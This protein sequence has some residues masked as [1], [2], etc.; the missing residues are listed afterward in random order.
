VGPDVR[1]HLAV[2]IGWFGDHCYGCKFSRVFIARFAKSAN[3]ICLHEL[4]RF[5]AIIGLLLSVCVKVTVSTTK[6]Q[7]IGM[8]EMYTTL[9]YSTF[10]K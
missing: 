2:V 1:R 6:T 9:F 3:L 7:R 4:L 8:T 5:A 10:Y